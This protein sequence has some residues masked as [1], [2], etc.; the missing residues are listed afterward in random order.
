MY[1]LNWYIECPC[2]SVSLYR[3]C[4]LLT[5]P[6]IS[7]L[8][9]FNRSAG[10]VTHL[11]SGYLEPVT[12]DGHCSCT[13][14]YWPG[15][16]WLFNVS[17]EKSGFIR[18]LH[19]RSRPGATSRSRQI[20]RRH[21]PRGYREGSVSTRPAVSSMQSGNPHT[22]TINVTTKT[23]SIISAG[24]RGQLATVQRGLEA[25]TADSCSD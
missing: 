8:V 19:G 7:R 6:V 5:Q 15:V 25:V 11:C 23:S 22:R 3:R 13:R 1:L 20:T 4:C 10:G 12:G 18:S 14:T 2:F 24:P 17:R 21:F 9:I 16:L